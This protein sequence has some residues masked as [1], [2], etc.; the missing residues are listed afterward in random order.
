MP[1]VEIKVSKGLIS[2]CDWERLLP[3]IARELSQRC[4]VP[5]DSCKVWLHPLEPLFIGE[6]A[7]REGAYIFVTLKD[8]RKPEVYEGLRVRLT[9]LLEAELS[10]LNDGVRRQVGCLL[11]RIEPSDVTIQWHQAHDQ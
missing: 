5:I 8:G 2:R 3:A 4:E 11:Q 1:F 10:M 6:S 9:E 7:T